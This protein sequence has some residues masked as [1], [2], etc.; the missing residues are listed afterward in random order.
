M[1]LPDGA[2]GDTALV[3]TLDL[4]TPVVNDP[5]RFG[6]IAAANALSD[7]YA[8]GGQPWCAMNIVCFPL[9]CQPEEILRE[10][11]RGGSDTLE[12]AETTLAGG[13]SVEDPEIK[14]GLSV[15]GFVR[16]DRI[17]RNSALRP[18]DI[19]FLTKPLGIGVLSTAVKARWEGSDGLE[20]QIFR[21][22]SR[23]QKGAAHAIRSL[24][25][26]AATDI[27][28]FGLAGHCLE[29]ARASKAAVRLHADALPLMEEARE[30]AEF[31]LLPA[32]A[33]SNRAFCGEQVRVASD[34]DLPL[35]DLFF[36]P[37]TSG[38]MLLAV[39]PEDRTRLAD[40]LAEHGDSAWEIGEVVSPS[41]NM[42]SEPPPVD[43]VR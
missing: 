38:G 16:P 14:Y 29:M 2:P 13:H 28:G 3:Q 30:L 22:A 10:I 4:L 19:L 5:Y 17:A 21:W 24:D 8:M 35:A 39:R 27:T 41:E 6:R 25:I 15:T 40:A 34:V 20:E 36:D 12:E 37:Q 31:G 43:I 9:T 33:H 23:L 26:R 7:I 1:R 42:P 11:L 32:G 18:G